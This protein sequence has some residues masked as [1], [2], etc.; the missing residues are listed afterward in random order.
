MAPK[1]D[2]AFMDENLSQSQDVRK[3]RKKISEELSHYNFCVWQ[4]D[5]SQIKCMNEAA[6]NIWGRLI[7]IWHED[8][9]GSE[10][11]NSFLV[12]EDGVIE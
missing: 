4:R 8:A 3:K 2:E 1:D 7:R 12:A 9:E 5:L 11:I 6:I 10:F